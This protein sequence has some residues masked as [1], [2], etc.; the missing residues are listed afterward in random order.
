M[1]CML[2]LTCMGLRCVHQPAEGL[3]APFSLLQSLQA[4]TLACCRY[5][6]T[7][8]P[9]LGPGQHCSQTLKVCWPTPSGS[10]VMRV[11]GML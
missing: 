3:G 7:A 11:C 2:A 10:P 4:H 6:A 8:P 9:L 5:L 1:S